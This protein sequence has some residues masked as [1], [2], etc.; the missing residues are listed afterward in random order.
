MNTPAMLGGMATARKFIQD[1]CSKIMGIN[2]YLQQLPA[3]YTVNL[4]SH[5]KLFEAKF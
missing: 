3:V 4:F 5:K 2:S 1:A